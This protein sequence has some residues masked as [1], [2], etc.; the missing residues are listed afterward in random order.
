MEASFAAGFFG[1]G[2]PAIIGRDG[3]TTFEWLEGRFFLIQRVDIEQ[4]ASS[5]IAIIGAHPGQET[6][7]QLLK[8]N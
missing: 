5:L 6:F 7:S 3:R 2:T 8:V 4:P 1:P